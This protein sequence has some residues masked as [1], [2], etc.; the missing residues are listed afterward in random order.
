MGYRR[1]ALIIQCAAVNDIR[2]K[3]T[4]YMGVIKKKTLYAILSTNDHDWSELQPRKKKTVQTRQSY[5]ADFTPGVRPMMST[6]LSKF[7]LYISYPIVG[8]SRVAVKLYRAE[9]KIYQHDF[10]RFRS[11]EQ[12]ADRCV[13]LARYDFLLV[14]CRNL[15]SRKNRFRVVGIH[16]AP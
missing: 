12:H 8:N 4:L 6:S 13:W 11:S 3:S 1:D 2:A 15:R 7:R 9:V 10:G 5:I 14:F 16:D